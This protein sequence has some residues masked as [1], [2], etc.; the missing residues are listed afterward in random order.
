MGDSGPKGL[1]R[2]RFL[3]NTGLGAAAAGL[4]VA[5]PGGTALLGDLEAEAPG[6]GTATSAAAGSA[7]GSVAS[8]AAADAAAGEAAGAGPLTAHVASAASGE[9]SLFVGDRTVVLRDPELVGR[10]I[11]AAG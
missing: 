9:L 5:L 3:R 1:S 11:R 10:L 8:S 6:A 4:V 7:V 2:R